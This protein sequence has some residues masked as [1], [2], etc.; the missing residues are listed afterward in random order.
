MG[1]ASS[2]SPTRT[3]RSGTG[4]SSSCP[5]ANEAGIEDA[6]VEVAS[7][8][9]PGTQHTILGDD[10]L[11]DLEVEGVAFLDWLTDFV[12]GEDVGDVTCTECDPP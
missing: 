5:L 11:Y 6:G 4:R 7:Y 8:L 10:S 9:A 12:A 2:T 1:P 3:T